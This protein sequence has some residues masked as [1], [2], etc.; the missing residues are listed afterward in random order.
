MKRSV[1]I[2]LAAFLTTLAIPKSVMA[3]VVSAVAPSGQT[4]YYN[5]DSSTNHYATVTPENGVNN[6]AATNTTGYTTAPTGVLVIPDSITYNGSSYPVTNIGDYA[7]CNCQGLTSVVLPNTIRFIG[8][9][10]FYHC[11]GMT[12]IDFPNSLVRIDHNAFQGCQ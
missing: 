2:I 8:P 3:Y 5:I 11:S 1:F 10:A 12:S 7:F 6:Y 4:L 9:S